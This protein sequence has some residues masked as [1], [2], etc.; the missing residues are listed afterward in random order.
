MSAGS[1]HR[2]DPEAQQPMGIWQRVKTGEGLL[3]IA[4][5]L[6]CFLAFVLVVVDFRFSFNSSSVLLSNQ[7]L[8]NAEDAGPSWLFF[9]LNS[10]GGT[11]LL[12]MAWLFFRPQAF[13]DTA[14]REPRRTTLLMLGSLLLLA[15]LLT[16]VLAF[17]QHYDLL[18]VASIALALLAARWV[19]ERQDLLDSPPRRV[20][21]R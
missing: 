19:V 14:A 2:I 15:L 21:D 12:L 5:A 16:K 13:S 1:E 7:A 8:A 10:L 4:T 11:V 6:L 18:Y 17:G 20:E 3:F 9:I